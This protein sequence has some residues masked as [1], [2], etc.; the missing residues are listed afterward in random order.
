M[1]F[2]GVDLG[3]TNLRCAIYDGGGT[4]L[5]RAASETD[6]IKGSESVI[7]KIVAGIGTVI[8]ESGIE[9]SRVS[10]V[11]VG[12][13]GL[14]KQ[15]DGFVYST[16]NM[17]GW[18][19]LQLGRI[20]TA[21]LGIPTFVENDANCAG[22][23]EFTSGAGRGSSNMLMVTLGTGIGSALILDGHLFFGRDGTAG[24]LG[25]VCIED[26]GRLCGCGARG[27]VEAYASASSVRR[28]FLEMLASGWT[29]P[30]STMGE[31][32]T[33]RDIFASAET[34]CDAVALRIVQET[35]HYLGVL[36]ASM[37]E[38]LN[39]ERCVIAGGMSLAGDVLF[40]SIRSTCLNR[41]RRLSGTMEILPAALG[42][43]AGLAGAAD[44]AGVCLKQRERY[45]YLA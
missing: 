2:I 23:A 5:A 41:N 3:G 16:P 21:E 7:R 19:N 33:T 34:G 4:M 40:S 10:A 35:G 11:C 15:I 32:V 37:A 44:Y 42:P 8:G 12:I 13:P 25:H 31:A 45:S 26:G 27:C 6:A 38:L 1:H 30:L 9:R 28:R 43:D 29:S 22:W 39:P 14:V 36:A 20:L 17:P 24:E 18:E